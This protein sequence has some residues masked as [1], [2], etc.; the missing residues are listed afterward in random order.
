M[1]FRRLGTHAS[2]PHALHLLRLHWRYICHR[3]SR[4]PHIPCAIPQAFAL[5]NCRFFFFLY[6]YAVVARPYVLMPLLGFLAAHFYRKG[7]SQII[8][9]AIAVALLIQDSSYA[10]VLAF[11][12]TAFYALRIVL[13]WKEV[14]LADRKRVLQAASI[15]LI[16][17][18][19]AVAVLLPPKDSFL[20]AQATEATFQ[21]RLQSFAEGLVGALSD[22]RFLAVLVLVLSGIWA[23]ERR[24]LPLLVLAVGGTALEYGFLRGFN[25]HQGLITIAFVAFLWAVWPSAKQLE[26]L[27]ARKWWVH[28]LLLGTLII[29]FGWQCMWS[30]SAIRGDWAGPYTGA[31]DAARFLKSE[32]ADNLGCSG[33]GAWAMAVQPY[34]DHNIFLNY[35][36]PDSP[37]S[38]HWSVEFEKRADDLPPGGV[39]NGTPFILIAGTWRPQETVPL[40]EFLKARDYVLVHYSEGTRFF[41]DTPGP[42]SLFLIFERSEFVWSR[43]K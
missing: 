16:S 34:F 30:Y 7:L 37:A 28:Q 4:C 42:H 24:G 38:Y 23:Y 3:W 31:L 13:R 27:P 41:K 36:G 17:A 18:I 21:H 14:S 26:C 6:Q 19:F 32:N 9:F 43:Q 39:R 29:L 8:Y 2:L 15:I 11:A 25:H 10:A 22:S 33:Y 1:A 40:V 12:L 20:V 35:G 5:C